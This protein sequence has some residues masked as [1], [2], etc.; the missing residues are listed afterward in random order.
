MGRQC[1]KLLWFRSNAKDQ[2]P[3][4]DEATQAVF[5][6]GTEADEL[7]Q[8]LFPGGIAVASGITNPSEP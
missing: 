5:E 8:R 6:Q 4:P 2:I 3:S 7:A 1:S